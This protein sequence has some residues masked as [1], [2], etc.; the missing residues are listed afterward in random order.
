M[1]AR[2]LY[3]FSTTV[4]QQLRRH[5]AHTHTGSH[6]HTQLVYKAMK[7]RSYYYYCCCCCRNNKYVVE[8]INLQLC[9]CMCQQLA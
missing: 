2:L 9:Q 5:T 7:T 8:A 4:S 3:A 6:T 1:Y